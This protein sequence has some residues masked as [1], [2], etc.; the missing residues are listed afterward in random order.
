MLALGIT[1]IHVVAGHESPLLPMLQAP[2]DEVAKRTM[3]AVWHIV[4]V[5]LALSAGGLMLA[6]ILPRRYAVRGIL[7]LFIGLHYLLWTVVFVVLAVT[8]S[9]P[10]PLVALPQWLLFLPVVVLSGIGARTV[11]REHT[12]QVSP[13]V[14][15]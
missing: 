1:A 15:A 13:D 2:F 6:G 12:T 9:L 11:A 14:R 3:Y 4:S 10:N 8:S 7:P 5:D